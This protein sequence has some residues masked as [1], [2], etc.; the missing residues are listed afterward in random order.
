MRAMDRELALAR[1]WLRAQRID[2][3]PPLA[4][5]A[6]DD[7]RRVDVQQTVPEL[8]LFEYLRSGHEALLVLENA[9]RA[10]GREFGQLG[11]L[12]DF[13]GGYGR[14]L[15]HLVQRVPRERIAHSDVLAPALEFVRTTFGVHSFASAADM[16]ALRFPRRYELI[17]AAS[18]FSHLPRA[19]FGPALRALHAALEP[20]GLLVF[21]TH[22]PLMLEP[23]RRDRSG[24]TFAPSSESRV[25]AVEEYGSSWVEPELVRALC[26]EQGIEHVAL[27]ERE[28]WRIQDVYIA[29]R[30]PLPGPAHWKPA[31]IA[32][33][34]ILRASLSPTGHAWIGGFVRVPREHAPLRELTVVV[35]PLAG[36]TPRAG[37]PLAA[38]APERGRSFSALV[39]EHTQPL[40]PHE[41]GERMRQFDWFLEGPAGALAEEPQALC[42]LAELANG[43]RSCF[44]V[45]ALGG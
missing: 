38:A 13:A 16:S 26:A 8:R 42:A 15:R 32:R 45:G 30:E 18:L 40:A 35:T 28:L 6:D 43:A 23:A 41:G 3:P 5:H 1:A 39:R 20:H 34:S 29:S 22:S 33:G 9:L 25:L 24:F 44:A 12:L 27:L 10:A 7:M 19:R 14:V 17:F 36:D 37:T 21:S 31:P 2:P 11:S 4:V